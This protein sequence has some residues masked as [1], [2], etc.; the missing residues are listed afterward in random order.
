[1]SSNQGRTFFNLLENGTGAE[2]EHFLRG[3]PKD[4]LGE[5]MLAVKTDPE[6]VTLVHGMTFSMEPGYL[7]EQNGK[8]EYRAD[9]VQNCLKA[10]LDK[11]PHFASEAQKNEAAKTLTGYLEPVDRLGQKLS[12]LKKEGLCALSPAFT[13]AT[14]S[15]ITTFGFRGL[16]EHFKELN[17]TQKA[18]L[19]AEI[20]EWNTAPDAFIQKHGFISECEAENFAAQVPERDAFVAELVERLKENPDHNGGVEWF[21]SSHPDPYGCANKKALEMVDASERKLD[22]IEMKLADTGISGGE[23]ASLGLLFASAVACA[24]IMWKNRQKTAPIRQELSDITV[25]RL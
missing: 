20:R 1:M 5:V 8:P 25:P 21:F 3:I 22:R 7:L 4:G 19:T 12:A 15:S 13:V 24:G 6:A 2:I 17:Q 11:N 10:R 18:E 14:I 9:A 16:S 23:A